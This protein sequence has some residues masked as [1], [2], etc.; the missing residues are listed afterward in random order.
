[1]AKYTW[2][3]LQ[4]SAMGKGPLGEDSLRPF[5]FV[6]GGVEPTVYALLA[7]TPRGEDLPPHCHREP[8]KG[9]EGE[10]LVDGRLLLGAC[11]FYRKDSVIHALETD[12]IPIDA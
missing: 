1:M 7:I 3:T 12:R 8:R 2:E 4:F 11:P 5:F 10:A 9:A 6:Y